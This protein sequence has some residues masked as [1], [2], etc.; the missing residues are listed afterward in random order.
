MPIDGDPED[1]EQW[2]EEAA[3]V[4]VA[5]TLKVYRFDLDARREVLR[6]NMDVDLAEE[7]FRV[8][9]WMPL[10]VYTAD[11]IRELLASVPTFELVGVYDFLYDADDPVELD[12][13]L[14]D[15][16]FVLKRTREAS[17]ER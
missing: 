17:Q 16:V 4:S 3:G 12:E 9:S 11:D 7:R 5:T 13:Y 14:S 15:A 2:T 1:C 10:R 8:R 6:V